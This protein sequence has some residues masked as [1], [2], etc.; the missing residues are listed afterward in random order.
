MNR[1]RQQ[2]APFIL[3]R[4]KNEV[5]KELPPKV[6]MD[7]LCPLTDVQRTEY[8]RICTEGLARLGEDIGLALREKSFGFL[9]LLT[10]L[11]QVC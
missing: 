2:V 10:R 4:T 8:A 11:R 5:A 3:R 1:L 7:L 9:A 6:E